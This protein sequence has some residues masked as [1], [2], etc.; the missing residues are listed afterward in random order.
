MT[1]FCIVFKFP[2][3]QKM[4]VQLSCV[5]SCYTRGQKT[6]RDFSDL[7]T[8]SWHQI[9]KLVVKWGSFTRRIAFWQRL[10]SVLTEFDAFHQS[11]KLQ[12]FLNFGWL[13][14]ICIAIPRPTLLFYYSSHP[15][16][17]K[18]LHFFSS[19]WSFHSEAPN[20][21]IKLQ[22]LSF[23]VHLPRPRNDD[24]FLHCL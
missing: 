16:G 21:R 23:Y 13:N 1:S 22:A 10:V 7:Q 4:G 6:K 12:L 18:R 8:V 14:L 17:V 20:K 11:R 3:F 9:S 5:R 24:L 2:K 19:S 15:A